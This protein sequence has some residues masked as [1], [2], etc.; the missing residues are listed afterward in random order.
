MGFDCVFI[1]T[2]PAAPQGLERRGAPGEEGP[3]GFILY[4][5][6]APG[7]EGPLERRGAPGEEGPVGFIL[8]G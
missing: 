1:F 6:R 8:K 4:Y 7:E 5:Y 2:A 3:V